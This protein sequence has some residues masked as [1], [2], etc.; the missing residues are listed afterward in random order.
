MGDEGLEPLVGSSK[1]DRKLQ[2]ASLGE[3]SSDAAGD[4]SFSKLATFVAAWPDLP[5]EVRNQIYKV[6]RSIVAR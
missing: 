5:A 6:V 3:S 2:Q 1:Q 4:A